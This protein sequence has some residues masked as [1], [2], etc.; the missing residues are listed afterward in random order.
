MKPRHSARR[1]PSTA[2][3]ARRVRAH[4]L[5]RAVA[6]AVAAVVSFAGT[7]AATAYVHLQSNIES[8]DVEH[9]LGEDRPEVVAPPPDPDDP[10]QGVAVNILVMGTD[11]RAGSEEIVDD[12]TEGERS[13][14]TIVVHISADR[15]RVELVS[16][17]R[18][19]LVDIPECL[20]SDGTVSPPQ[21]NAMFNAA[22]AI[23]G[24]SGATSDAAACTQRTVEQN[25][26]L[27]IDHFVVINLAGF[28]AMVDALGGVP[29][30]IPQ[31]IRSEK[32]NNL[33]LP[34][35]NQ[36]LSGAVAANY[37][38]AR[39]GQGLGNGSDIARIGRQQ[40]LLAA[41][42]RTVLSKNL[43]TDADELVRFLNAVTR[44]L[45]VSSGLSSIPD[46]TGLAF[47][48]R[49]VPSGNITFM[50]IPNAPAPSDPNRVV[51][52]PEA[53][54]VWADL[55][56][57]APIAPEVIAEPGP[58][59]TESGEPAPPEGGGAEPAP[60][61]PPTPGADPFTPDDVTA[62]CG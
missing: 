5:A 4:P 51:W 48:L 27:R 43:L 13:D 26:G 58:V 14:T 50:T 24:E 32:A 46:M 45:T 1:G 62:V 57:D 10:N 8:A 55:A 22:F 36:V 61:T 37:A 59:P 19:S 38:R 3:H 7:G 29:I 40:E 30:C 18:D 54:E 20:R 11:L 52:T 31:E 21:E 23:G 56:A 28:A 16:I 9:L 41:V 39:T 35:G 17:P 53:E 2:R 12:G 34:A 60:S 15:Q 49:D 6:L 42:A 44:S 25:T 33:H 47:S